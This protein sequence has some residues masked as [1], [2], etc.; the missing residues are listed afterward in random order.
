MN[1]SDCTNIPP[2]DRPG[3]LPAQFEKVV[4]YYHEHLDKHLESGEIFWEVA[5]AAIP[6][7]ERPEGRLLTNLI[8]RDKHIIVTALDRAF[9]DASDCVDFVRLALACGAMVHV[10]DDNLCLSHADEPIFD[11]LQKLDRLQNGANQ[12]QRQAKARAKAKGLP[13]NQFAGYGSQWVRD[14]TGKA[15]RVPHHDER[16][17]M[18]KLTDWR[19]T[20]TTWG[21]IHRLVEKS[22]LRSKHGGGFSE[23]TL[24]R[25]HEAGE[26]MFSAAG[27]AV[28]P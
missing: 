22:G 17:L 21:E 13:V 7:S 8:G 19:K 20:G 15:H 23:R 11:L 3:S 6:I 9:H 18:R 14:S 10:L 25:L 24:R 12:L 16:M 4:D 27:P 28:R 5:E 1:L 26:M 2:D